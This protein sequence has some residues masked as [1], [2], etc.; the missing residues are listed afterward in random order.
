MYPT[1]IWSLT[2]CSKQGSHPVKNLDEDQAAQ[3]AS[4]H[5]LSYYN[6]DVHKAAFCLPTYIQKM[7]SD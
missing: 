6:A 7:I 4:L 1:G 5:H 2:Y 3:F